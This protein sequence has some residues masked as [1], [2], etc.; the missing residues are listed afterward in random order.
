MRTLPLLLLLPLIL[1]GFAQAESTVN[2]HCFQDREYDPQR[3]FAADPYFLATTQNALLA[4]LFGLSK[5]EVVRAKMGG[6]DG[7]SL[8]VGHYLAQK[9][10]RPIGEIEA[11]FSEKGSWSGVVQQL[12][13]DPESLNPGFVAALD[14]QG[15]LAKLVVDEK[16]GVHLDEEQ[17]QLLLLRKQGADNKQTIMAVFLS[18]S[19]SLKSSELF[20]Q[21]A[22]GQVSWG[23]L[24]AEQGLFSGSDIEEKWRHLI[25]EKVKD[26]RPGNP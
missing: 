19:S 8:W 2:C 1:V 13:V 24:L 7:D 6:A 10:A 15:K 17:P 4:N 25:G 26:L 18:K 22:D 14:E 23:R 21:V 20:A 11:I 3:S 12:K 5:K 16:L 9:S